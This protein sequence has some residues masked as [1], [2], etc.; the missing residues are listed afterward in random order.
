MKTSIYCM[1][2]FC[3]VIFLHP[4][5]SNDAHGGDAHPESISKPDATA[6]SSPD[7]EEAAADGNPFF[8]PPFDDTPVALVDDEPITKYDLSMALDRQG[9]EV[10]DDPGERDKEEYL[11][12]L[13]RL[14][15]SRLIVLEAK[16]IGLHETSEVTSQVENF[17]LATLQQE[18]MQNHLQ[19]LE[20][21]PAEVEELYQKMSREVK[22]YSL[23]FPAGPEARRFLEEVKEGDFD[24]IAQRYLEEGKA[25]VKKDENYVKI[26]DLRP[27]V[28]QEV[29][30][31]DIGGLSKI[32]RTDDGHLLYRLVDARFVEDPS[33][34]EEAAHLVNEKAKR[35]KALEYSF[36]LQDK[37]VT[38][39]EEL[40]EQLDFETDMEQLLKDKR[41]LA[42]AKQEDAP[43]FVVTVGDLA[44][45]IK[46]GFFHGADKAAKL[47]IIN[48]RKK[49]ILSN[50][51][52]MYTSELEAR[53]LGL[54]ETEDF[55][56]KVEDFERSTI[57]SAFMNRVLLPEV[58]V[59]EEEIRAYYDEHIDEF[60]SSPMLRMKS[61]VFHNRQDAENALDKLRKGADYNWVSANAA[62]L[63]APDNEE[64]LPL[65]KNLLSLTALPE[66]LH[67]LVHEAKKNDSLVYAPSEGNFFYLLLVED[68][69]PPES[70]PYEQVRNDAGQKV[71]NSKAEKVL[72]EWTMKLKEAYSVEILLNDPAQ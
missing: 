19:G 24:Q 51:I 60:S 50:M 71:F 34:R 42:K 13:D 16:N 33:V 44:A 53:R 21:D 52:F 41:V 22:L 31:M 37:Y 68:V 40:F 38:F 66:D 49:A 7:M 62:N 27:E 10:S 17:K 35:E 45:R 23:V 57:F 55:Q 46:A 26:K 4:L 48:Q 72:D 14:I 59:T 6:I 67:E 30:S 3:G 12:A 20:P 43:P 64:V 1:I 28:G 15:N 58:K 70:Q 8:A 32:Y 69:F 47:K 39:D 56:R 18:L 36:A 63:V 61:L 54:D 9:K 2:I 65:D 11:A 29:Y 25:T 5:Y